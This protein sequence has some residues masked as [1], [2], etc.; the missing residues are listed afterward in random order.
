M[1]EWNQHQVWWEL[2]G[3]AWVAI[4][5]VL[6]AALSYLS[7]KA[8][9]L[10]QA[11]VKNEYLRGV[12]TRL[13]DALYTAV[14]EVQQVVVDRIKA[15]S[16]KLDEAAR[17]R[18]KAAALDA[19]RAYFGPKGLEQV[20]RVLGI[21]P[22]NLERHLETRL[23]ATVYGLRSQGLILNGYNPEHAAEGEVRA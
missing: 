14:L 12:L 10:L 16:G 21:T 7:M 1:N 9:Q 17:A 18:I 22:T 2:A 8:A 15:E 4:A 11:K 13:D 19:V 6:I 5:P 23:E 3:R 20:G